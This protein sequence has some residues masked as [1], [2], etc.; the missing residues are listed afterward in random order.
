VNES[1]F[2]FYFQKGAKLNNT[3]KEKAFFLLPPLWGGKEWKKKTPLFLKLL[4]IFLIL[5]L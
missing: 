5:F 4:K 1:H 2:S 3:D